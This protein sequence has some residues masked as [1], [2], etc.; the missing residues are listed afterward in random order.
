MSDRAQ[1]KRATLP[2]R[3]LSLLQRARR[4]PISRVERGVSAAPASCHEDLSMRSLTDPVHAITPAAHAT[5]PAVWSRR[6]LLTSLAALPLLSSTGASS[7]A[8]RGLHRPNPRPAAPSLRLSALDGQIHDLSAQRGR[9]VVINFWSVYCRACKAEM[10]A[11]NALS[12]LHPDV[13]VWGVAAGDSTETVAAYAEHAAVEFP[14][15]PDPEMATSSAWSVPVLPVTDVIDPRGRIAMRMVG[16][17]HWDQRPLRD[18]VLALGT[19]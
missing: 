11:L 8:G 15:L 4:A 12:Q 9:V 13:S 5:T 3:S 2:A 14:L 7:A 10:P 1:A 19:G 17:A 16:E 18:Q 6:R